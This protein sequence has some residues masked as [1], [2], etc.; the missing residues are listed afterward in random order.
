MSDQPTDL[1]MLI[2]SKGL[3]LSA[4]ARQIQGNLSEV[5]KW[6]S[7]T[8]PL[9]VLWASAIAEALK[10]SP[11]E[12]R[13]A[14]LVNAHSPYKQPLSFEPEPVADLRSLL[15]KRRIK[16]AELAAQL[17]VNRAFITQLLKGVRSLPQQR[18]LEIAVFLNV[19]PSE[20]RRAYEVHALPQFKRQAS[21]ESAAL[22]SMMPAS[23]Q[24]WT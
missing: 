7:G 13:A 23:S 15:F 3:T 12:V 19:E 6:C 1:K 20:V 21:S 17:R 24:D 14:Y 22:E 10:V 11:S 4:L 2:T 8:R 5:S 9:D 16:P 18:E